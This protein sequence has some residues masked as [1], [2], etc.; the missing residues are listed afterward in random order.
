MIAIKIGRTFLNA[1]NKQ[2]DKEYT[3]KEF[4]EKVHFELFYNNPKYMQWITNS[5]F[6]QMKKGQKCIIIYYA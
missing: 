4:F 5:P 1:Y 2:Y 3:A 6:V